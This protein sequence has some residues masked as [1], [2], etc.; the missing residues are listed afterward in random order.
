M[1]LNQ[2]Q[3]KLKYKLLDDQKIKINVG[4]IIKTVCIPRNASV[5]DLPYILHDNDNNDSNEEIF[6]DLKIG[7]VSYSTRCAAHTLYLAI[8]DFL[9]NTN[10]ESVINKAR[11]LVKLLR[12][13]NHK[14]ELS[15]KNLR[16]P[17][18]DVVTR[19]RHGIS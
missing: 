4:N 16:K 17:F 15:Q 14:V 1:K 6:N 9:K 11:D 18:I 12:A 2:I 7:K 19:I 8:N 10:T 13:T 5:D 3:V